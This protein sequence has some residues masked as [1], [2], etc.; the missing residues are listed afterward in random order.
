MEDSSY[1][2]LPMQV[3]VTADLL[4]V[5]PCQTRI[6]LVARVLCFRSLGIGSCSL[7]QKTNPA[8]VAVEFAVPTIANGKVYIGMQTELIVFCLLPN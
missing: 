8:G 5:G 7:A 2:C 4:K 6:P 1:L 3:N